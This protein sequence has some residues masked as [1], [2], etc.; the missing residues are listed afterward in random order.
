M[1]ALSRTL[2]FLLLAAV[3]TAPLAAQGPR[4]DGPSQE[5]PGACHEDGGS[6]PAPGPTS[7]SCCLAAHHPAILQQSSTL[8]TS[9]HG[10]ARVYFVPH[11]VAVARPRTFPN[12]VIVPGNP[13]IL[14]PLR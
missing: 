8:R 11:S 7:H 12:L 10:S 4:P 3:I 14:S 2:V 13:P 1:Q 5:R 9:L 6:V